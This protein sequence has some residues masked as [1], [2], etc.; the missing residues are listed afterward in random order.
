MVS[1]A[2][3]LPKADRFV[4]TL[5]YI[6]PADYL[7]CQTFSCIANDTLNHISLYVHVCEYTECVNCLWRMFD[8]QTIS[9][10]YVCK[11]LNIILLLE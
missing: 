9:G 11:L 5:V 2:Y 3:G 7:T 4:P 10:E 8:D 6:H 1:V